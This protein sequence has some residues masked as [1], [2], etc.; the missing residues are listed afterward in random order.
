TAA[1]FRTLKT[2][3]LLSYESK[4][5]AFQYY[6][7]L[8]R[9]TD[10]TGLDAPK[11]RYQS[12]LLMIRQWRYL[13]ML[14]HAARGH[15]K[16]GIATTKPGS[17]AVECPACP[18]PDKN[19]PDN[20]RDAPEN[21]K[22]LHT[23]FIGIDANF[24]LK[25]KDVS[26]D[27]FDPDLGNGFA[28][29]VQEKPYKEHLKTHKD[30][31]EPKSNCSRHN[32]INLANSKFGHGLA[33]TGVGT[34]ECAR[35]DM[36]RPCSVGDLQVDERYCNI[37][38]LF[39]QSIAQSNVICYVVSYDIACQW[40]VHLKKRMAA[41]DHD[42]LMF[43]DRIQIRFFV[44][45]FHLSAHVAACRTGF[46]FNYGLGVGRTDG[47]APERGW[48]EINPLASSTKEMGPGSR[49][50]ALDSHF[51]DY[52]WRKVTGMGRSLLRKLKAATADMRMHFNAHFELNELL[53]KDLLVKWTAEVEAWEKNPKESRNPFASTIKTPTQAAIR[54][55]LAQTESHSAGTLEE[56][57]L[58]EHVSSSVLIAC[59]M[60][61][62]AEQRGLKVEASKIWAHSQDRQRTKLQLRCNALQHKITA[63]SKI[64]Q[65]YIPGVVTLCHAEERAAA[66]RDIPLKPYTLTLWLPSQIGAK[67]VFDL[68]LATVEWQLRIAQ[69][70]EALDTL[71][72]NLQ[73]RSH[74]FKF[75]DRFIRGQHSNTRARASIETVQAKIQAA[76][77]EYRVA[78]KALDSLS[79]LDIGDVGE[80]NKNNWQVTLLP[81]HVGDIR[82]LSEAE[83]DRTS[84]GRR[85]ISWIWKTLGVVSDDNSQDL[86]D[87]LR[88]EW[89]KSRAWAMRFSEEVEL[90]TEEMERVLRFL[91]YQ[92]K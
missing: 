55:K 64:H 80:I 62:E 82:E 13:K 57:S 50:D 9:L 73:I 1:T 40:S 38:Y 61:I 35:H 81:L 92:Q 42:F 19:M 31:V 34:I 90:L 88:I 47:E 6:N 41:L 68:H 16:D 23:L 30:E 77:E 21:K 54:H 4:V 70:Y 87:V 2:F 56:L 22:W 17:C 33:A 20:W 60:D 84:E 11:D 24:R 27:A 67:V 7:A 26:C 8:A 51:S 46:S 15:E 71:R 29:F 75:K 12:L 48:A 58:D 86:H 79:T 59:G 85:M 3:E 83:D 10:N 69:A 53:P 63:W 45:K 25:R 39:Y 91:R 52:N 78:Y 36:K 5:S 44:P 65:L 66:T 76:A 74:L 72:S 28:Y 37:D 49:R 14:K 89:C 43:D 32:A 18:H